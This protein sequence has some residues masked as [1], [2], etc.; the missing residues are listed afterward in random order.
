M[1]KKNGHL[2]FFD[3]VGHQNYLSLLSG[4]KFVLGNSSSGLLEAPSF[5]VPTINVGKRQDGRP[6]A[7]SVIDVE[8]EEIQIITAIQS[9][10]AHADL[11]SSQSIENPYG[12]P[13]ASEKITDILSAY[14]FESLLPKRF[15][16]SN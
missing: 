7:K 2:F 4:A 12:N 10:I 13:G 8:C 15:I 3:T 5:K 14:D 9:V 11:T 1:S 6:R 16:D